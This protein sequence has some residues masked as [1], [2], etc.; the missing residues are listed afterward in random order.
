M[1]GKPARGTQAQGPGRATIERREYKCGEENNKEHHH[2]HHHHR[3]VKWKFSVVWTVWLCRHRPRW[4]WEP[5]R[6]ALC[7]FQ[8]ES[9]DLP[10]AEPRGCASPYPPWEPA[11]KE[12]L[13]PKVCSGPLSLPRGGG[14][15]AAARGW[16]VPRPPGCGGRLEAVASGCGSLVPRASFTVP[17]S[18][19]LCDWPGRV[20]P[21]WGRPGPSASQP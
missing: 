7:G 14:P 17:A 6:Q 4:P 19:A 5:G 1:G 20:P 15:L 11:A 13:R 9:S 8:A 10:S 2:H 18:G 16:P 3:I 12:L 21:G